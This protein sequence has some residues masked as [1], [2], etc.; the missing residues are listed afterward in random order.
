MAGILSSLGEISQVAPKIEK[1]L[2][3]NKVIRINYP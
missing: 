3:Q 1:K 2:P